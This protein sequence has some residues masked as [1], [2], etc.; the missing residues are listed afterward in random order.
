MKES[1]IEVLIDEKDIPMRPGAK[2]TKDNDEAQENS[3]D[4]N[5]N[6][7]QVDHSIKQRIV[8]LLNTGFHG[9][10]NE[11]EARNAMKLARRLIERQCCFKNGGMDP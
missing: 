10:S 5:N 2:I 3:A 8:K 6:N 7:D 9:E 1:P 4:D 11:H